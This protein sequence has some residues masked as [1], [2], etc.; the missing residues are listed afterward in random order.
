MGN[1]SR[2]LGS[3]WV[4][5]PHY[6]RLGR[7]SAEYQQWWDV[8]RRAYW[9]QDHPWQ[10]EGARGRRFWQR[11]AP[12]LGIPRQGESCSYRI[13]R[14]RRPLRAHAVVEPMS[15]YPREG[16]SGK[17]DRRGGATKKAAQAPQASRRTRPIRTPL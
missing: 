7:M 3:N 1:L 13:E 8:V 4:I 15:V 6:G 17:R 2:S 12:R 14:E 10:E 16:G 9:H 5:I 11:P